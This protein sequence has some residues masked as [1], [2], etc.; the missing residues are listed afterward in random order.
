MSFGDKERDLI[1]SIPIQRLRGIRQL[2]MASLVYPGAVHTRF[3]HTL[4]VA[5]LAG[6]MAEAL[7]L[8]EDERRLVRFAALLHDVGH[9]IHLV[10]LDR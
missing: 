6:L 7:G 2:A 8:D 9:G 10:C 3:D 4:G 5:H 1:D